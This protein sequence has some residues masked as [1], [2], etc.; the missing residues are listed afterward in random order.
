MLVNP[1][2]ER[3]HELRLGG[4]ATA[5]AEQLERPDRYTDLDF[6]AR[7][8]L[9]VDREAA[10]RDNRR[11]VRNLKTARLRTP[12]C[13]EDLDFRRPRGLDRAQILALAQA[14]W[15][16]EHRDLLISGA[17]GAGKT[18]LACALAQAAIRRGHRALYW[19]L[20]RLLDALRLAHADGTA[21]QLMTGW[22]RVD[23]LVLDDLGLRPLTTPQAA[24][25][26]EVIED[27]HQ[28]R[29]TILT[30][31]LPINTW[32]DNLG[33][34]TPGRRDLRPD[35]A[36]RDPYRATRQV[37]APTRP[38]HQRHPHPA[39][40]TT[41]L[42]PRRSQRPGP[43]RNDPLTPGPSWQTPRP[44]TP[45]GGD[46]AAEPSLTLRPTPAAPLQNSRTD[47]S[48]TSGRGAPLRRNLQSAR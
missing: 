48:K 39:L 24:D 18:Y 41:A 10:D 14:G 17:T 37:P 36:H 45:E 7:L 32:H 34:P 2:V 19:R 42:T 23:L 9:L 3:L 1:T 16:A 44:R 30:S 26:L 8:G 5:L 35:P 40:T 46:P 13:V 43:T 47:C 12:A 22:A 21:A 33:D 29:S 11:L 38:E 20:P 27:R 15:V 4:M 6:T 31:Q 28:R 25:L